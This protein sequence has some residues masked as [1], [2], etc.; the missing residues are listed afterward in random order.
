MAYHALKLGARLYIYTNGRKPGGTVAN[1]PRP[2][3]DDGRVRFVAR[4]GMGL[5]RVLSLSWNLTVAGAGVSV[6]R[7][8]QSRFP[9]RP[10]YRSDVHSALYRSG[11]FSKR[12]LIRCR[13]H[14][15]PDVS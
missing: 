13:A 12:I 3:R 4:R 2:Y 14:A 1:L 10:V 9:A 15:R 8:G 11:H 5:C 7:L 6:A